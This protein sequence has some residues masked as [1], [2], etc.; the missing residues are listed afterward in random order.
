MNLSLGISKSGIHAFQNSL[1]VIAHDI[2]NVNTTGYKAKQVVFQEL[3]ENSQSSNQK[4]LLHTD[5]ERI[6]LQSGV[7]NQTE[8]IVTQQGSLAGSDGSYQLA[9][10]GEGFFKVTNAAGEAFLSRDGNFYKSPAGL[11]MNASGEVLE[12]RSSDF[13]MGQ[14]PEGNV[15]IQKN[16]SIV[17]HTEQG[18]QLVGKIALYQPI[19]GTTLQETGA[20]KYV[21]PDESQLQVSLD[22]PASFG[23]ITQEYL[24]NSN[25]DLAAKMSEMIVTQR[26][27]ALNVKAAQSTD[28]LMGIINNFKQ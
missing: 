4:L 21:F 22:Q 23:Q 18:N 14:W 24:E 11:L 10:N 3:L 20:N 19:E 6:S 8:T 27:Y 13:S 7:K 12:I 17:I 2:A 9:I 25:V 15:S 5:L 28:E 1:D 26:A 16:G